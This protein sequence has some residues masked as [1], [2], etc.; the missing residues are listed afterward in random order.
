MK[1]RSKWLA[2]FLVLGLVHELLGGERL[3]GA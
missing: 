2:I 3:G 1:I